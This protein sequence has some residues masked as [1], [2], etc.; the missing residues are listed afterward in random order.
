MK[1]IINPPMQSEDGLKTDISSASIEEMLHLSEKR[2]VGR[3][4][5]S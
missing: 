1:C 2:L 4:F 5:S 3:I